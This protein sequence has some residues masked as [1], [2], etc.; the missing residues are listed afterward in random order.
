MRNNTRRNRNIGT[1][2]QGHGQNNRLTIP[3]P[4]FLNGNHRFFTERLTHYK[5]F[6]RTVNGY[7]FIFAVE[8]P[9]AD[10]RHACTV[11]DV[12]FMLAQIPASDYGD[13]R[14]IVFRQPKRKEEILSPVWGRLGYAYRFEGKDVPAILLEAM[15][16]NEVLKWPKSMS[17]DRQNEFELLQQDGHVFMAGKRGY[18][19]KL[20][21][22]NVRATQLYRTL[23]HEFGHYVH[24]R[25]TVEI[26]ASALSVLS[27]M[28]ENERWNYYEE[29]INIAEKEKFAHA[30]ADRLRADLLARGVIPFP[31]KE[32]AAGDDPTEVF[33]SPPCV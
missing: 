5:R 21:L 22:E 28:S 32:S 9:R 24:Y 31:R 14:L 6:S 33:S 13:L 3:D 18:E 16:P 29:S 27:G 2:K 11:D 1:V 19:A 7:E 15:N 8:T 12:A 25:Q 17:V 4:Y 20:N 30:Y 23:S 10:C 26:P